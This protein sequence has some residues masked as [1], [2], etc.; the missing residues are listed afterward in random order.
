MWCHLLLSLPAVGLLFFVFLP[1]EY[2]LPA[3]IAVS[4]PALGIYYLVARALRQPVQ[5]GAEALL[6]AEGEVTF[7]RPGSSLA[8]CLVRCQGE[9]WSAHA[10]GPVGVGTRVRVLRFDGT[11]PVVT[12]SAEGESHEP[13]TACHYRPPGVVR[14][15]S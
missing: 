11:R 1:L 8:N 6:G 3:Y 12:A 10:A 15:H 14:L 9:L 13:A 7:L 2:A 4:L 5:T